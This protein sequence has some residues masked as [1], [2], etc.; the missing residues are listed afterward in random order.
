MQGDPAD[1]GMPDKHAGDVSISVAGRRIESRRRP[2]SPPKAFIHG[3]WLEMQ[4]PYCRASRT[5]GYDGGKSCA[6]SFFL[7]NSVDYPLTQLTRRS[8]M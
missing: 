4:V 1:A 3:W 6:I 2:Q 7:L 8:N 5:T